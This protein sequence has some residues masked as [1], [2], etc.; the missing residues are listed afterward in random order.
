[1]QDY[2]QSTTWTKARPSSGVLSKRSRWCRDEPATSNLTR[3][4]RGRVHNAGGER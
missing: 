4:A 2:L 1:M 3:A